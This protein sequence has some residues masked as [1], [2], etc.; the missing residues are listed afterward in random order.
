MGPRD[1]TAIDS[2]SYAPT[3]TPDNVLTARKVAVFID[4]CFW[5]VRPRRGCE[6]TTNEW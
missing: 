2:D 6:P 4:G 5:H 3:S 1:A